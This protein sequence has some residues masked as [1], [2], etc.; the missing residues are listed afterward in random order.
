MPTQAFDWAYSEQVTREILL[1][2]VNF[3]LLKFL[4][5]PH[6]LKLEIDTSQEHLI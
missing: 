4:V 3:L 1:I 5:L 6:T 2:S